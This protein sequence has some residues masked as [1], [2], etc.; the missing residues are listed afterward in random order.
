MTQDRHDDFH[1]TVVVVV[2]RREI[3]GDK[4]DSA[5]RFPSLRFPARNIPV[6]LQN[7]PRL[8]MQ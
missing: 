1:E 4:K 3:S 6:V 5:G 2:C 8:V 7:V